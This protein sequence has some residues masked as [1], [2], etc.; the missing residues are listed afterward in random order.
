M[1]GLA[2]MHLHLTFTGDSAHRVAPAIPELLRWGVTTLL[3]PGAFGTD[4]ADMRRLVDRNDPAL[5]RL[6]MARGIFTGPGSY[7]AG[8]PGVFT[9]TEPNE[10]RSEVRRLHDQ[11]Y[12]FIKLAYSDNSYLMKHPFVLPDPKIMKVVIDEAHAQH[13]RV[14]VHAPELQYAKEALRAG[15]DALAHGVVD[16]PVDDEF[17]A[18]LRESGAA[19]IGTT[20]LFRS[21]GGLQPWIDLVERFDTLHWVPPNEIAKRRAMGV[22][23]LNPR[24]DKA[25]FSAEQVALLAHNLHAVY[26][27][28]APLLIGT[29]VP[30]P[31]V[32]PGIATHLEMALLEEAGIPTRDVLYAAT[33][34]AARF[35]RLESEFGSVA[36]GYAA[37]LLVLDA[38][39]MVTVRNTRLIR[40]VIRAGRVMGD[41]P[42]R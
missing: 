3:N 31:G 13:M 42:P 15:C 12:R 39:P 6:L 5:P 21:M 18:L 11:G 36:S 20:V 25:P 22:T 16:A 14:V 7:S 17:L 9:P 23:G 26:A 1:P 33:T 29:D 4:I 34:G 38:D 8:L 28:G 41:Q 19:Y 40:A 37:D 27:A 10:A 32:L 30:L 35:A 24:A 2:D